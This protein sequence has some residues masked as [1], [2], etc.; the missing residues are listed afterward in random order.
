MNAVNLPGSPLDHRDYERLSKSG[1]SRQLANDALIRRVA[2]E[3]GAST[4]GRKDAADYSGILFPYMWP[5]EDYVREYRLRRD[6]PELEQQ[7]DGGVRERAKYV[8]PPGR[9]NMLYFTPQTPVDWLTDATLPIA[10]TEGEKKTLS[11]WG[12]GWHGMGDV[13]ER[14]RWLS[15]G[16]SGVWNWR[17]T[18]GKA[19]GPDGDRRDVKGPIPD[20]SRVCWDGRTV[21]IVF[22]RNVKTNK[23]VADAR[24][25]LTK[26][27]T[28]RGA[29]VTIVDLPEVD[30]VNGIDDLI[31]AWGPDG[32]LT[33]ISDALNNPRRSAAIA[34]GLI[35]E[36]E[37]FVKQKHHF[38]RDAGGLLYVFEDGVYRPTGERFVKREVKRFCQESKEN[39]TPELASRVAEYIAVDAPELWERPPH[40]VVNVKNGLL[41]VAT[42]VLRRHSPEFLSPVQIAA[43]YDANA[44]C[45]AIDRFCDEVLPDDAQHILGEIAAWL[46]LPET[47]IQKAV[48]LIGEGANGKS[49][50]LTLLEDFLSEQNVSSVTLHKIEMDKF[51]ASRLVGK[52]ANICAD[53]PTAALSGTSMFKALT[54]GDIIN[55]E[56][57]FQSS[58]EYRPYA[59]LVFSANTPPRSDDATPGFFRRWLVIPF[60]RRTFDENDPARVPSAILRERLSTAS[61][62]SGLLNR[63]L[64]AV[65][66]IRSGALRESVSMRDAWQE[67]RST[68]DPLAVWLDENT[69]EVPDGFVPKAKL[70][71]LYSRDC[72]DHGRISIPETAFTGRLL[73][74]RPRMKTAQRTAAK[75]WCF[76]GIGLKA[77][78][79]SPF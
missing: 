25:A 68:T 44:R 49:V 78:A 64:D 18:V 41:G 8:S 51:A 37:R 1:I 5:G 67:F 35:P 3:E 43:T 19:P 59:R 62:L 10:I 71:E 79:A 31:G 13:A 20:L 36:I 73:Q 34:S 75:T 76:I 77:D 30:G 70:R 29:H 14:P 33:L 52:L 47:S 57:K 21:L 60:N 63:A 27:L 15:V 55:A 48:L 53:L 50:F 72:K 39:W 58:F 65:P 2:S 23:S 4:V 28:K 66:Q 6:H 11:L 42:R 46:M 56:R 69:V 54:G 24:R 61:E 16:I 17:G 22:D 32:V 74:L 26:E 7:T 12:L 9:G 38:A 40:D 45:P